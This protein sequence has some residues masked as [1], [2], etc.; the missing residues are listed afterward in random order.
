MFF[1]KTHAPVFSK[2]VSQ[3]IIPTVYALHSLLRFQPLPWLQVLVCLAVA[4]GVAVSQDD[5]DH[6]FG[7]PNPGSG[8][9][10]PSIPSGGNQNTGR[11]VCL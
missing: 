6:F 1:G 10:I 5:Y 2:E 8:P 3:N 4:V 11:Y 9:S 7:G